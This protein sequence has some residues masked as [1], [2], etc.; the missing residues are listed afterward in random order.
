MDKIE[1]ELGKLYNSDFLNCYSEWDS[2]TAIIS[3]GPYGIGGYIG[4]L[5]TVDNLASWYKPFLLAWYE[6]S[7]P[8]TTLW[9][10]NT[11]LGWASVHNSIVE[12]GWDFVNCHTWNKGISHIAGNVNSKT[13]RHFPKVTEVCVQYVRRNVIQSRSKEKLILKDWLRYEWKRTKLPFSRT[14][15]ACAVKNAATRKYFTKCHLWYF[16]PSEAFQKFVDYANEHGDVNGKPYFSV[17]GINPLSG[18]EWEKYRAKFNYIHGFTNVWNTKPLNGS[19]RLKNGTKALH[20]NQKPLDL[21][22]LI[23]S[24]STDLGDIIWEPFGGLC[25]GSIAATKLGRKFFASEINSEVFMHAAD[26]FK[27]IQSEIIVQAK[28]R[29][30]VA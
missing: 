7:L 8:N 13:I 4:D 23:I 15:I 17:D 24:A 5:V 3:D 28:V 26:R 21:L 27:N 6:H 20:N 18:K 11:E 2:P 16:P 29:E 22:S 30:L 10:W 12:S 14:N 9:F 1:F 25:S 19:E